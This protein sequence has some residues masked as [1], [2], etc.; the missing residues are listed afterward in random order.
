MSW[1]TPR[2]WVA[3]EQVTATLFNAQIRDNFK[4][5]GEWAPGDLK[6]TY[7]AHANSTSATLTEPQGGWYIAN[8]ATFV[9]ATHPLL[10]AALGNSTTLPDFRGRQFVAPGTQDGHSFSRGDVGGEY[11]HVL[12]TT[13]MPAH[14]HG[15]TQNTDAIGAGSGGLLGGASDRAIQ[16]MNVTVLSAGGGVAHPVIDPFLV[17]GMILIKND[18]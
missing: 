13:E 10:Y 4:A 7:V 9:Q 2:T 14:T 3:G 8:G 18:A 11:D 5:L 1:T 17:G 12:S 6:M 16:A 15:V